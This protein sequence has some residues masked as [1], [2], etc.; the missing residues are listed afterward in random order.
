MTNKTTLNIWQEF[1]STTETL[2]LSQLD[3]WFDILLTHAE[4]EDIKDRMQILKGLL[5]DTLPQRELAEALGVSISKIT[6]GSNALK[7]L[8]PQKRQNLLKWLKA[9]PI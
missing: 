9:T 2:D 6:R 7:R 8:S 3:F 4:K 5:D 1:L